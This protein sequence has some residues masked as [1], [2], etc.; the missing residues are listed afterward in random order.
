MQTCASL[1]RIIGPTTLL[2]C[3]QIVP[4][5]R[6]EYD[7]PTCKRN[8]RCCLSAYVTQSEN[9]FGISLPYRTRC[10]VVVGCF[11]PLGFA[12][13]N[14]T[15]NG[16]PVVFRLPVVVSI[17]ACTRFNI[18]LRKMQTFIETV[19]FRWKKV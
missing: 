18:F 1:I 6:A 17:E 5:M 3:L 19:G 15:V 14:N 7:G 16:L 10:C 9:L 8:V 4:Q 2:A 11:F 12:R 13:V